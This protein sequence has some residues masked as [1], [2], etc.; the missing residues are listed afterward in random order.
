[1]EPRKISSYILVISLQTHTTLLPKYLS[2][3][4]IALVPLRKDDTFK[5]VIPSKIFEA[6]ALKKPIL[7]GVEGESKRI[8][9]KYSAGITYKPENKD[10]FIRSIKKLKENSFYKYCQKG[11]ESLAKDYSRKKLANDMLKMINQVYLDKKNK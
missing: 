7:L 8:I 2:I 9:E 3:C 4:D 5:S 10:D 11:C 6:A 1:M